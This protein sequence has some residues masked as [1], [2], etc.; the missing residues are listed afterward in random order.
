MQ[1]PRCGFL[2]RLSLDDLEFVVT[3]LANHLLHLRLLDH[4]DSLEGSF[5]GGVQWL[6]EGEQLYGRLK[7]L[8]VGCQV[9]EVFI[10]T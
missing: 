9:L 4:L 5:M 7:I 6:T 8:N 3:I 1:F 10:F 2:D